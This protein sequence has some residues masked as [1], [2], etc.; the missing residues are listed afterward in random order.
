MAVFL[1]DCS[2]EFNKNW[3]EYYQRKKIM[4]RLENP[5]GCLL[6]QELSIT[7]VKARTYSSNSSSFFF[8]SLL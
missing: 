7:L 8:A 1:L 4:I 6:F 2:N 3:K 5:K